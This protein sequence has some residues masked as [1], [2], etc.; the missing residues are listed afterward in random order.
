M[1]VLDSI[2][3]Q[4]FRGFEDHVVPLRETTIIVGTNNAGK[5][6]LVEALRLV[7]LVTDRFRRGTGRFVAPPEWLNHPGAFD[8]LAPTVR[9]MPSEG[10]EPSLFH[11]Y[12]SPPAVLTGTFSSGACVMVFVGPDAQVHGVARRPDGAPVTRA[13]AAHNLDFE[14]L[15]VQPQVAPLL[16]DEPIRQEET[17]RRGDGTYLAPQHFR[18]QLWLYHDYYKDFCTIAEDTW[19]DLQI[20]ALEGDISKPNDP[21]RLLIRDGDFVG[22]VSLMGHGLQMWLQIVWFLARAPAEGTV[23][24]DEPDVYMHPDLQRRLLDLVRSR[25]RQLVIATHSIEIVSDVDPRD[26]LLVNRRQPSS[27]FVTSL[28][29]LQDVI[30]RLGSLQNIQVARLMRS[31]SFYLV[32]GDDVKLL[33]ILQSTALP[34]APPID[35]VPHAELGGRGGWGSGVPGRL[36]KTNAEGKGIRSFAILDRDYF[37]DG[38]VAERYAEARRW[39]VQ[40]RVW[41]RK[42]IENYLLVPDAITRYIAAEVSDGI[43]VPNAD[44]V[45]VEI[46]RIVESMREEPIYDSVATLLHSRDKKGGLAK[47]N[48]A[49]RAWVASRWKTRNERW[50]MAPG[51]EVLGQLSEWSQATFGTGFGSSQI[52][53]AL[54]P[55]EVDPEVVEVISAITAA[56]PLKR[57]YTMPS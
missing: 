18:N 9:G 40:L 44:D 33:R 27:S 24:L 32:E 26:I 34:D 45:A 42:E 21:L 41:S 12:G 37:P 54:Q 50:A 11:R 52:A 47:A 14:P 35:L 8:G 29:G 43:A 39:G 46:D 49:A 57:P 3:L 51:K 5:S 22:E 10:F 31:R 38:E 6:T 7:A 23:V 15:A 36:P 48:K 2:R 25:F 13:T 19:P 56:R 55:A 1:T 53:R 17:I 20:K 16:R 30:D 28:P 4:N